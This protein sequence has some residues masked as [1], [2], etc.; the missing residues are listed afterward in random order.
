MPAEGSVPAETQARGLAD[1][2]GR[3]WVTRTGVHVDRIGSAWL[4]RRFIDPQAGF[5]FVAP[6]GYV[7]DAGELRFDM[8]EAEFTHEGELCTFEVLVARAGL[9]KDRG[10]A[11][12]AEIVHDIDLKDG[13]FGRPEAEG[14]RTVIAGICN[15]TQSDEERL[16]RGAAVFEDLYRSFDR[17]ERRSPRRLS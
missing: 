7:P 15:G 14:I 4:I 12:I 11:A 5:K 10:L 9:D 13:K 16:A 17:K 3:T 8:F 2:K 1:L 6:K